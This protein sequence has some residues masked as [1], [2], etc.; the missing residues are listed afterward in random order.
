MTGRSPCPVS[1]G[2]IS[3]SQ[4]RAACRRFVGGLPKPAT[5]ISPSKSA[6]KK[7]RRGSQ[8]QSTAVTELPRSKK[9]SVPPEITCK[10]LMNEIAMQN[11][12]LNRVHK[13][14]IQMMSGTGAVLRPKGRSA[15]CSRAAF[16]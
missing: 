2:A 5:P 4:D 6:S 9:N 13:S 15:S 1:S 12:I 11:L 10:A 14:T 16:G 7:V 3:S 8:T